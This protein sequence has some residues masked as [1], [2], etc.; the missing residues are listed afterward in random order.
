M[1]HHYIRFRLL[2]SGL[3]ESSADS[4]FSIWERMWN[5]YI[6]GNLLKYTC[7]KTRQKRST[8]DKVIRKIIWCRFFCHTWYN[9]VS[10]QSMQAMASSPETTLAQYY[11][12][13]TARS[14]ARPRLKGRSWRRDRPLRP[15]CR[16]RRRLTAKC[17]K[18]LEI[19][20]I[21]VSQLKNSK[22]QLLVDRLAVSCTTLAR[23]TCWNKTCVN[24]RLNSSFFT[25]KSC[26]VV[27]ASF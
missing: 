17:V 14:P 5:K 13:A 18:H 16:R 25:G 10:Y 26:T 22:S 2:T 23:P 8:F 12:I 15:S 11:S 24:D 7:A 1:S 4:L 27:S 9:F 20:S 21:Q 19:V 6:M 3:N